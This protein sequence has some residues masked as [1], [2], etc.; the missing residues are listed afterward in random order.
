MSE[1]STFGRPRLTPAMLENIGRM[2]VFF[3]AIVLL[4]WMEWEFALR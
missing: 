4:A 2:I 3:V 1:H